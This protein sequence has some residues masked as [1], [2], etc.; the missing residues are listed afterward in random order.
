MTK[1][2]LDFLLAVINY[3]QGHYQDPDWGNRVTDQLMLLKG[4]HILASQIAKPEI[5]AGIV[6]ATENGIGDLA[7]TALWR[8]V[9]D[10]H[11]DPD[12]FVTTIAPKKERGSKEGMRG[13]PAARASLVR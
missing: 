2:E 9:P 8:S 7:L 6:K 11:P 4:A 5:R 13:S 12:R 10:S 3:T 1:D